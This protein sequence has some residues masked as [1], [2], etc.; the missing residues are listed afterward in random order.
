MNAI[1]ARASLRTA[2]SP[3]PPLDRYRLN[4]YAAI[5]LQALDQRGPIAVV[6]MDDRIGFPLADGDQPV[7][8]H[9][10]TDEITLDGVGPTLRELAST[11]SF[12]V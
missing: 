8:C 7:G 3:H 4:H 6:A 1:V 10:L 12:S 5:R 11:P 9:A 2:R